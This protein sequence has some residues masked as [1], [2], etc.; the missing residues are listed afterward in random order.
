R[1]AEAAERRYLVTQEQI[2]AGEL[3]PDLDLDRTLKQATDAWLASLKASGS[4]SHSN[5]EDR[6][7]AYITP[8]LGT[9]PI[10]N[11]RKSHVMKWRDD[12]ATQYAATTVNGNLTCLSSAF[13]YFVD[14]EWI[15][16][17]PC[18]GVSRME[19]RESSIYTW[20]RT[21]EEITRLLIECPKGIREIVT[22]AA[23]TGMRLDELIH[24][25]WAD[26]DI[27][28]RL[29]A[30]HR[31]RHG[32]TKSGKARY[33]PILDALLPFL[34]ELSLKRGGATL[35]FP[36]KNGKARSKPGVRFPFKQAVK[37]AGLPSVLRFHDLRHT[38]ASHWVLDG[39]DIF[40]LSKILGHSSVTITQKVYAHLAP[41]A[42]EQD[43]HRVAFVVPDGGVVYAFTTR[44]PTAVNDV[45]K[46]RA[47]AA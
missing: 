33:I 28:R 14:Q 46:S 34:R 26:I 9:V 10:A 6:V 5:Y 35:V 17:N 13:S 31:G 38:F 25:Q 42:W 18:H 39:G 23:G 4:R 45:E 40:R 3:P 21:R 27:E 1:E 11:I 12:Q 15:A 7:N 36:G 43:Y 41:E 2:A 22:L 44:K 47:N 16:T 37:R 29:I 32:T 19:Q 30:V 8:K 20:I 24:L